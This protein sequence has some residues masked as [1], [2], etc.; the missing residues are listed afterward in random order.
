MGPDFWDRVKIGKPNECWPWTGAKNKRGY[1]KYNK[2]ETIVGRLA[3][4]IAYHMARGDIPSGLCVLHECDN[5][6]CCNPK[7]LWLGTNADN[8]KDMIA[9]GRAK[10][11]MTPKGAESPLT[12]LTSSEVNEIK[13]QLE[14]GKTGISLAHKYGVGRSTISRIRTGQDWSTRDGHVTI[15]PNP[16]R[17]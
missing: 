17:I 3:H 16:K 10:L 6:P 4:R 1:G 8:N 2:G 12:K 15:S 14:S 7:H 13:H 9:K 11:H 5:P